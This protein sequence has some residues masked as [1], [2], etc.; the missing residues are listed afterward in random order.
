MEHANACDQHGPSSSN[1]MPSNMDVMQEMMVKYF[2]DYER[3]YE[4]RDA[5]HLKVLADLQTSLAACTGPVMDQRIQKNW[6][7]TMHISTVDGQATCGA[8]VAIKSEGQIDPKTQV[9]LM[10]RCGE[11]VGKR[12]WPC[13]V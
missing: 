13:L 5:D 2:A 6:F 8:Y 11:A 10:K 3:K 7:E 12:H 9:D 4:A 1:S